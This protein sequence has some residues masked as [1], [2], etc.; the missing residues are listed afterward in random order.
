MGK[1]SNVKH[2][3]F[4]RFAFHLQAHQ[5]NVFKF[6]HHLVEPDLERIAEVRVLVVLLAKLVPIQQTLLEPVPNANGRVQLLEFL[7]NKTGFY[8]DQR[9]VDHLQRLFYRSPSVWLEKLTCQAIFQR[10]SIDLENRSTRRPIRIGDYRLEFCIKV[11]D[12]L[13]FEEI[14]GK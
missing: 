10:G 12:E 7:K 6:G 8:I 1:V 13:F 4:H 11:L 2:Q 9:V 3:L 14:G 5:A